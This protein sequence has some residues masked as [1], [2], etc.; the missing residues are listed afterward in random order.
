VCFVV[1]KTTSEQEREIL[2]TLYLASAK[3]T[4]SWCA[5]KRDL[6]R[7]FCLDVLMVPP[8]ALTV[9]ANGEHCPAVVSTSAKPFTLG[10][11]SSSLTALVA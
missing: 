3:N 6:Q 10:D 2:T 4:D 1:R 5:R 7:A 8:S 11:S 9:T